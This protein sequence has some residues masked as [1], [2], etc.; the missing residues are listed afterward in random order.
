MLK[1]IKKIVSI[2][3]IAGVM[4]TGGMSQMNTFASGEG[5][6]Q[7]WNLYYNDSHTNCVTQ[8]LI[9][10]NYLGWY[11]ATPT[12]RSASTV[13]TLIQP[14]TSAGTNTN[15]ASYLVGGS[16]VVVYVNSS[17]GKQVYLIAKLSYLTSPASMSGYVYHN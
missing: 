15:K 4:I 17:N 10:N 12:S 11:Y 14:N 7:A 1:N 3:A 6:S 16:Q 9:L 2:V 13:Y 5:E 8:S